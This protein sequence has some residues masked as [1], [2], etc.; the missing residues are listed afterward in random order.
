MD[1]LYISRRRSVRTMQ[2][3]NGSWLLALPSYPGSFKTKTISDS[4]EVEPRFDAIEYL[5]RYF[6]IK[7]SCVATLLKRFR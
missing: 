4:K 1:E 6:K 5:F 3:I 7:L 2:R